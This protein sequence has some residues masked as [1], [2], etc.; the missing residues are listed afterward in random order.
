MPPLAIFPIFL[1]V[2]GWYFLLAG[3]PSLVL[4]LLQQTLYT[5]NPLL[6]LVVFVVNSVVAIVA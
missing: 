2:S 6:G 5:V 3:V 1:T 4:F